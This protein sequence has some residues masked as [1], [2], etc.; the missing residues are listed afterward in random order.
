MMQTAEWAHQSREMYE[1]GR[2]VAAVCHGTAAL[3]NARLSNGDFL[4]AGKKG[5]GFAYFDERIAAVR[6]LVP[7]IFQSRLED[8]GMI[9]S[10]ARLPLAGHTVVEDRLITG[11]SPN[12]STKTAQRA[13][14]IIGAH[15]GYREGTD[16][17]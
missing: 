11:Q 2:V 13:L 6:R 4:I 1:S 7:C 12:S 10:K 8:R 5:T 16:G 3:Q 17:R 15:S 14:E 9:Y